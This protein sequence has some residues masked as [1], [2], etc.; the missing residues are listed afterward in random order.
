MS[1]THSVT[2]SPAV[3]T[4][5]DILF[6][7]QQAQAATQQSHSGTAPERGRGPTRI[8]H[9]STSSRAA[10]AASSRSVSG[11]ILLDDNSL[12]SL[13][14]HL[15]I[16]M[17]SINGRIN[18]LTDAIEQSIERTRNQTNRTMYQADAE[19]ERCRTLLAQMKRLESDQ[20]EVLRIRDRVTALRRAAEALDGRLDR[21][22]HIGHS[23]T[24]RSHR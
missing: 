11:R 23:S 9:H 21:S 20:K 3:L 7:R 12:T 18:E 2:D 17:S 10:S 1:A 19:L 13:G 6:I 5:S 16:I 4:Q 15:D 14:V 22:R 24:A 8:P